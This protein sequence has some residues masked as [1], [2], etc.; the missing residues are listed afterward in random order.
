MHRSQK[1]TPAGALAVP[2]TARNIP[3]KAQGRGPPESH[4]GIFQLKKT[5]G[6][7]NFCTVIFLVAFVVALGWWAPVI[8]PYT[9]TAQYIMPGKRNFGDNNRKN[10]GKGVIRPELLH[11]VQNTKPVHPNFGREDSTFGEIFEQKLNFPQLTTKPMAIFEGFSNLSTHDQPSP[12]SSHMPEKELTKRMEKLAA[13]GPE[14]PGKGLENG[15]QK[16]IENVTKN[17]EVASIQYHC[18]EV[19][20]KGNQGAKNTWFGERQKC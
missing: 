20:D 13:K 14:N 5:V 11:N 12:M 6:K 8:G 15:L 19:G 2:N 7:P 18:G 1:H 4:F 17:L 3:Q 9:L 16:G 10:N